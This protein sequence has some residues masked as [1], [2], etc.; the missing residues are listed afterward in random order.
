MSGTQFTI[1]SRIDN[2]RFISACP[3]GVAHITWERLTLR[4]RLNE[5]EDLGH[6]LARASANEARPVHHAA[7]LPIAYHPGDPCEVQVGVLVLR[8]S[9][10]EFRQLAAA[11]AEAQRRLDEIVASGEWDEPE[12]ASP[13]DPFAELKAHHFS[14]N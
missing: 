8:L 7:S 3:H 11:V 10:S 4:L 14:T 6:L 1:L 12:A 5:F 13:A 9:R 2:V